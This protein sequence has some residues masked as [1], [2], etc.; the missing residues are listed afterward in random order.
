MITRVEA[1]QYRCLQSVSQELGPFQ[2]LV[3]PNGSGKSVFLDVISFLSTFMSSGL[4]KAVEDRS[5][6]FHDLVWRRDGSCF[7]LA[8]E[9]TAPI[10]H[11]AKIIRY[12]LGVRLDPFRDALVID[13][14]LVALLDGGECQTIVSRDSTSCSFRTETPEHNEARSEIRG[15][16]SVLGNVD[17]RFPATVWLRELL[18]LWTQTVILDNVALRN[19]SP[20]G[21]HSAKTFDGSTLARLVWELQEHSQTTFARWV[22]HV[23]TAL[24]DLDTIKSVSRPEDKTRYLMLGYK[25]GVEAPSWVLSDGTLRLLALTILAYRPHFKGVYLI[26]EPE[27]GIHPTALQTVH[28][29][30]SSVYDG[31]VL[32]TSHS[33]LLLNLPRLEQLLCFQKTP[34]GTEIVRGDKHPLLQNW[35]GDVSLSDLFAAGV[36]S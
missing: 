31:E 27:N 18:Q 10:S 4:Y 32:A 35:K 23:R 9:A 6:N 34:E 29:S 8:I 12:E 1:K 22:A 20:P 28:Q 17:H 24:P 19:P 13:K 36:F 14:E 26:E 15:T 5:L 16:Y 21:Q 3:G 7:E 11:D 30:L 2:V 33:P 25:N